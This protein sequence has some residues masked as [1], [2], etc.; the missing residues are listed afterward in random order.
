MKRNL[1]DESSEDEAPVIVKRTKKKFE[2]PKIVPND[3]D[4]IGKEEPI[5]EVDLSDIIVPHINEEKNAKKSMHSS[6]FD[7]SSIGLSMMKKMGFNVGESLGKESKKVEQKPIIVE[8]KNDKL[9]IGAKP[10]PK[11]VILRDDQETGDA[12]STDEFVDRMIIERKSRKLRM[13]IDN[14]MKYCFEISGDSD[15]WFEN[16]DINEVNQLWRSYAKQLLAR[17]ERKGR[18]LVATETRNEPVLPIEP[19]VDVLLQE[20]KLILLLEYLREVH[21]YCFFCGVVYTNEK[22]MSDNCPGVYEEDH[23]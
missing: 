3:E 22:D 21:L 15:K 10:K 7:L 17:D 4:V 23:A 11:V 19:T 16:K 13:T 1:F 18:V 8:T 20:E 12:N 9:G 2:L 6:L 5:E 14:V